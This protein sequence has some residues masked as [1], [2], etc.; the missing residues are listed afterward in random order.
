MAENNTNLLAPIN[1]IKGYLERIAHALEAL[2]K[3]NV[4]DYKTLAEIELAARKT[5]AQAQKS[6][7]GA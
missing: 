7:D 4:H 1:S 2:A 3:H 5:Q 6:Q